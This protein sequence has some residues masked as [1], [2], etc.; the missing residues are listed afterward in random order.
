MS[1]TESS[2]HYL[3]AGL[4]APVASRDGLDRTYWEGTKAGRLMIQRC[5]SC[6]AEQFPPE[7]ACAG[8]AGDDLEW[9]ECAPR[10][11]IYT[12]ERIWQGFH[13]ALKAACPYLVVVVELDGHPGVRMLGNLLGDPRQEIVIGSAVEAAFEPHGEY[14]LVQWRVI[15]AASQG[16]R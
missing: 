4:P 5:R 1:E 15:P 7:W 16:S 6:G 8:C 2:V 12:W 14:T 9:I 11:T 10:G 13:P 3:P